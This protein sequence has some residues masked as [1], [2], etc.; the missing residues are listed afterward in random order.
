MSIQVHKWPIGRF[1]IKRKVHYCSELISSKL[2]SS[3]D[4][5]SGILFWPCFL[6]YII[7][8]IIATI[9]HTTSAIGV[10]QM[11]NSGPNEL[12]VADAIA[13]KINIIGISKMPFLNKARIRL[14]QAFP[15][16]WKKEMIVYA[17]AE[18]G[19][20]IQSILKNSAALAIDFS[21]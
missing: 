8:K 21:S 18:N 15:T 4:G 7:N 9:Q 12:C 1:F 11:I 3:S 13:K 14:L 17:I 5:F 10:A 6:R 20:P 2:N 19:A 16:A